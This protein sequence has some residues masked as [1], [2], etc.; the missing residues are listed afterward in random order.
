[1]SDCNL[2]NSV[3]SLTIG[4]DSFT[5][6]RLGSFAQTAPDYRGDQ[7]GALDS[8]ELNEETNLDGE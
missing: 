8:Y 6:L 2:N 7:L 5:Y 1:M 4:D 3:N